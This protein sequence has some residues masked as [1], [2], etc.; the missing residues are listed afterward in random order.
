MY[1]PVQAV[2]WP[3]GRRIIAE[4]P[5]HLEQPRYLRGFLHV[6]KCVSVP[7]RETVRTNSAS[8]DPPAAPLRTARLPRVETAPG[9][10]ARRAFVRT[11]ARAARQI[12]R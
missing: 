3:P 12:E 2:S 11:H 9:F 4:P 10:T 7:R 5:T 8:I 6:R 1:A